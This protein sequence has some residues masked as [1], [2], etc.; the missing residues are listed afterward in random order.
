ME[1]APH[2]GTGQPQGPTRPRARVTER[3]VVNPTSPPGAWA[4]GQ[5]V[6]VRGGVGVGGWE[7]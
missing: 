2:T 4:G 6:D 7:P 3:L 5:E 1:L